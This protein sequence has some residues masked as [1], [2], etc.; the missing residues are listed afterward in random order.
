M[1]GYSDI[2]QFLIAAFAILVSI[3]LH[4][5]AHGV[6]ALWNGDPTAKFRGRL[7]LNPAAHFDLFGFLMLMFARIGY[8]KPVPVN[9]ANY[10]HERLGKFTVSLAGIAVNLILAFFAV[11][12]LI[13]CLKQY[14]IS[15]GA[16]RQIFLFLYYFFRWM[17]II[18]VNLILFNVLPLYPLDGYRVLESVTRAV[19]PVTKFMRNYGQYILITV[20]GI[21]VIMNMF[22]SAFGWPEWLSPIS[23][24]V[25]TVGGYIINGF[26]SFW[27]GV[28]G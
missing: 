20:I 11:P 15:D 13:V 18:N 10:R 9:P 6:V 1:F 21:S 17:T 12:L 27:L 14:Y 19:N 5:V 22:I 23:W 4:E 7:T 25:D 8:A 3:I 2:Y 24:Y 28:I 16:V 26:S